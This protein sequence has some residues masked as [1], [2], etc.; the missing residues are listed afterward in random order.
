MYACVD[1]D[2]Q[3]VAKGDIEVSSY[4]KEKLTELGVSVQKRHEHVVFSFME[5]NGP[6][7]QEA[8]R[9]LKGLYP[10]GH[11]RVASWDKKKPS[12]VGGTAQ[13]VVTPEGELAKPGMFTRGHMKMLADAYFWG[14][15]LTVISVAHSNGKAEVEVGK[16]SINRESGELN[17]N[18]IFDIVS[19][20][21]PEELRTFMATIKLALK[22]AGWRGAQYV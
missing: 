3:F 21:M 14:T 9:L 7:Y 2:I 10:E 15:N 16:L 20:N 18:R 17:L 11:F 12:S 4:N 6:R 13:V 1:F 8:C 19:E 22:D 5:E